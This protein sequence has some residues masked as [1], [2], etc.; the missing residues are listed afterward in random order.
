LIKSKSFTTG[1]ENWPLKS[2][3][4]YVYRKVGRCVEN[5][6]AGLWGTEYCVLS[7]EFVENLNIAE[8]AEWECTK[9]EPH[10]ELVNLCGHCLKP[11]TADSRYRTAFVELPSSVGASRAFSLKILRRRV[12]RYVIRIGFAYLIPLSRRLL[13]MAQTQR[14]S[15]ADQMID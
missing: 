15:T 8:A 4:T 1:A 5:D 11:T 2:G 3:R 13:T 14:L 6:P 12:C 10:P 7:I 9:R